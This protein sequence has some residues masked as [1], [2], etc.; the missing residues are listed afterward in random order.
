MGPPPDPTPIDTEIVELV[1]EGAPTAAAVR[2]RVEVTAPDMANVT[3]DLTRSDNGFSGRVTVPHGANR[4]FTV[5]AFDSLQIARWTGT[6]RDVA[7]PAAEPVIVVMRE[8]GTSAR[9]PPVISAITASQAR[10]E[11]GQ[12]VQLAV[13]MQ[14]AQEVLSYSW[15]ASSGLAADPEANVFS[16]SGANNNPIWHAPWFLHQP[17]TPTTYTL[18]VVVTNDANLSASAEVEV[19]VVPMAEMNPEAPPAPVVTLVPDNGRFTLSWPETAADDVTYSVYAAISPAHCATLRQL[20]NRFWAPRSLLQTSQTETAVSRDALTVPVCYA[21]TA[22]TSSG[23]EGRLSNVVEV[24][25]AAVVS[26][27][28]DEVEQL[29]RGVRWLVAAETHPGRWA[30]NDRTTAEVV[31]A[32]ARAQAAQDSNPTEENAMRAWEHTERAEVLRRGLVSLQQTLAGDNDTLALQ[33]LALHETGHWPVRLWKHYLASGHTVGGTIWGWGAHARMLPDPMRTALGLRLLSHYPLEDGMADGTEFML[34]HDMFKSDTGRYGWTAQGGVDDVTV[35][36]FV[37]AAIEA[38]A[39]VSEWI[40]QQQDAQGA[41]GGLVDTIGVLRSGLA[42]NTIA[43]P[44]ARQE[45]REF[46]LSAQSPTGSWGEQLIQTAQALRGLLPQTSGGGA[47]A[48]R[49]RVT[50]YETLIAPNVDDKAAPVFPVTAQ[51]R[52]LLNNPSADSDGNGETDLQHWLAGKAEEPAF[53]SLTP[54]ADVAFHPVLATLARHLDY[55]PIR[56]YDFVYHSIEFED[57]TGARKGALATYRSRRGNAWDQST[58]LIALLRMSGVPARYVV[59]QSVVAKIQLPEEYYHGEHVAVHVWADPTRQVGAPRGRIDAANNRWLPLLPWYKDRIVVQEGVDLFPG[60]AAGDIL[61]PAEL[62]TRDRYLAPPIDDDDAFDRHTQQS[63]LEFFEHALQSYLNTHQPGTSVAEVA[64]RT[65]IARSQVTVLPTTYPASAL[66]GDIDPAAQ[67]VTEIPADHRM[68]VDV[69]VEAVD[70]QATPGTERVMFETSL[71]LARIAGKRIVIDFREE[72]VDGAPAYR[73][74]LL[75]DGQVWLESDEAPLPADGRIVVSYRPSGDS[76]RS[77]PSLAAGTFVYLSFDSLQASDAAV[78]ARRAAVLT[79]PSQDALSDDPVVREPYLGNMAGL[80]ANT[81]S[82]R[83]MQAMRRADELFQTTRA[84][85]NDALQ[86]TMLWTDPRQLEQHTTNPEDAPAYGPFRFYPAF[87]ID[88]FNGIGAIYKS[89]LSQLTDSEPPWEGFPFLRAGHT[90]GPIWQRI[91]HDGASL[92]EGRIFEDVLGTPGYSTIES[93]FLA[94]KQGIDV[95]T[96][97]SN[98]VADAGGEAAV[99]DTLTA[100]DEHTRNNIVDALKIAGTVVVTPV[101]PVV[102][103]ET[104]EDDAGPQTTHGYIVS[105]SDG[106][107]YTTLWL[108]DTFNGGDGTG[109]LA[110]G[111]T[112]TVTTSGMHIATGPGVGGTFDEST[113]TWAQQTVQN[114]TPDNMVGASNVPAGD[115]VNLVTGEFYTEERPDIAIT[116]RGE[117]EFAIRRGYRSQAI[118]NGPF[119]FGWTWNHGET[120]VAETD[121]TVYYFDA[122]RQR[123]VVRPL[124]DGTYEYPPGTRFRLHKDGSDFVVS[125]PNGHVARFGANGRLTEKQDRNGNRLRFVYD[126]DERLTQIVDPLDRAITLEYSTTGKVK[127]VRDFGGRSVHYDYVDKDLVAFTDLA[128]N[129]TR[130]EVLTNQSQNPLNNHNLVKYTLPSGDSL[131]ISYLENDRV[132]WH[133]NGYGHRFEFHYSVINGYAETWDEDGRYEKV[134]FDGNHNVIRW[135]KRDGSIEQREYDDAHNMTALIDG[136]GYRTEFTYSNDG[137]RNL[138]S[139][140]NALGETTRYTYKSVGPVLSLVDSITDS[141]GYVTRHDYDA[142]GNR[143]QTVQDLTTNDQA[144]DMPVIRFDPERQITNHRVVPKRITEAAYDDYG[145]RLEIVRTVRALVND[146]LIEIADVTARDTTRETFEYDPMYA[147]VTRSVDAAG[148]LTNFGYDEWGQITSTQNAEGTT[149]RF[150]RHPLGEPLRVS[151]DGLGDVERTVFDENGRVATRIDAR[152]GE[153]TFVYRP[154]RDIVHHAELDHTVDP[155]GF[156]TAFHY[157]A[158]GNIVRQTDKNRHTVTSRYDEQ[159][160]VIARTNALGETERFAYNARGLTARSIDAAGHA[161]VFTY[162]GAGRLVKLDGPEQQGIAYGYNK[163]GHRTLVVN[164]LGVETTSRYDVDGNRI[165]HI[166]GAN[167]AE[168]RISRAV[169]DGLGRLLYEIDARGTEHHVT[170]K[171]TGHVIAEHWTTPDGDVV[172]TLLYDYDELGRVISRTDGRG[173]VTETGYDTLGRVAWT[174]VPDPNQP[175]NPDARLETVNEWNLAGD[176]ERMIDPMGHVT[177]YEYDARGQRVVEIAADGGTQSFAYDG[178]GNQIARTDTR[179]NTTQTVFD[180]ANRTIAVID[181]TGATVHIEYDAV[182][183]QAMVTEYSAAGAAHT[184]TAYDGLGRIVRQV[185]ALGH[186]TTTVWTDDVLT[187]SRQQ[188]VESPTGAVTRT[189]FDGFGDRVVEEVSGTD[190]ETAT[191]EF[192][193][194]PGGLPTSLTT[195]NAAGVVAWRY[196][197]D[198]L[199]RRTSST[200]TDGTVHRIAY[201]AEGAPTVETQRDGTVVRRHFDALGRLVEVAVDDEVQQ[202]FTY[203]GASRLVRAEDRNHGRQTHTTVMTLDALGRRRLETQDQ[204]VVGRAFDRA[205]NV[206]ELVYP[207]GNR[208]QAEYDPRNLAHRYRFASRDRAAVVHPYSLHY[209]ATRRLTEFTL[210]H[211]VHGRVEYDVRGLETKRRVQA[212]QLVYAND[213]TWNEVSLAHERRT[214]DELTRVRYGHDVLGRIASYDINADGELEQTWQYDALGNWRAL[215]NAGESHTMQVNGDNE[216]VS[217]AGD[218]MVYDNHGNVAEAGGHLFRYDWKHRLIE[219]RDAVTEQPIAH[220]TYDAFDRRITKNAGGDKV[221]FVYDG[222]NVIEERVDNDVRSFA[223]G[224]GLD[225]IVLMETPDHSTYY[226]VRDHRNSVVALLDPDGTVIERISYSPFGALEGQAYLSTNANP[227]GFTGRRWDAETNLWHYRQRAYSPDLG[228]FLQRDPLGTADGLNMYA[229]VGNRPLRFT[230]PLG[231]AAR[232]TPE[233]NPDNPGS[234]PDLGQPGVPDPGPLGLRPGALPSTGDLHDRTMLRGPYSDY[235]IRPILPNPGDVFRSAVEGVHNAIDAALESIA[236]TINSLEQIFSGPPEPPPAPPIQEVPP[237]DDDALSGVTGIG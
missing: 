73:P 118:Y 96:F 30:G 136:D 133:E 219:V 125:Q 26:P 116:T 21:V 85:G 129:T 229:Y 72:T 93:V 138:L 122:Q 201:D 39:D 41:F 173:T 217:F 216:Y 98:A 237:L 67:V 162:D 165:E 13:R 11:P 43:R 200:D 213:L 108:Y 4:T 109:Q 169:Y 225:Q 107:G 183:R 61:L 3:A 221:T 228:R 110:G 209:D 84:F 25:A 187:H 77:R 112:L 54:S 102:R 214:T 71:E 151:I 192:A 31:Y 97:T 199:G 182:G 90:F 234:N 14:P 196:G 5:H 218:T 198:A 147:Q 146:S 135:Q 70:P 166:E 63:S 204:H 50:G 130:F 148:Q 56:I 114:G 139:M 126:A 53:A 94:R 178:N 76:W 99:R 160:R 12:P 153:T 164:P 190:V 18:R 78:L 101:T 144:I 119:G 95:A 66:F 81:H 115:P 231:L 24:P 161:T 152:G 23:G 44:T 86:F 89:N 103:P 220:Y 49:P 7:V 19:E 106:T 75:I 185:D 155:L 47:Y 46:V 168:P 42:L 172:R 230:D 20:H 10:V 163:A 177:R 142:R 35:S 210:G 52:A 83:V 211:R 38:P 123:Y 224:P 64:H 37:Y 57:Y 175:S 2:A 128:G 60:T 174:A 15:S 9:V 235:R 179:G 186:E 208:L 127:T 202:T 180:A 82:L 176:L 132:A 6:T 158:V 68:A 191:T 45:A 194:A 36:A 197:F 91:A 55:D 92:A 34:E 181:A 236:N 58:L 189:T 195:H 170:R 159:N 154:A 124:G 69:R 149:T 212:A 111:A 223:Y 79:T 17:G 157:D 48:N 167:L 113:Q 32:L 74:I 121:G 104:I 51:E 226:Y 100:L 117:L 80:L 207:G 150:E 28:Q 16:P 188:T 87:G 156:T 222:Q 27:A 134:F 206:T 203:D 140:T 62:D 120:I 137:K 227:F 8:Q 40:R 131:T 145:N 205:G 59:G 33:L 232:S 233:S 22:T 88:N 29:T 141:R 1:L 143:V 215:T 184:E 65:A 171:A 193:Y 105:R